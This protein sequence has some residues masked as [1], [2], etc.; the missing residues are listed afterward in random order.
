MEGMENVLSACEAAGSV[1]LLIYMSSTNVIFDYT[2]KHGVTDDSPY[3]DGIVK[4]HYTIAKIEAE[5]LALTQMES[6]D[7]G[8]WQSAP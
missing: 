2:H 3:V 4:D 6:E 5:K 8:Q 7:F 1:E